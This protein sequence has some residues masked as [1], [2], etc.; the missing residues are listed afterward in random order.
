MMP[1][2]SHTFG[3]Q[4]VAQDERQRRIRRVFASVA[5]RYDLMNDAMS[6]GI[7]RLWKRSLARAAHPLPGQVI[8]DL[9]GGTGDVAKLMADGNRQVMVCDPS[10]E[11]MG[12]GR[13]RGRSHVSWLAG[14]GEGIPLASSSVDTLTI[15]FG[16]RNVT[17]L[18]RAL[19]EA[20]RVLKPGGRFLC[21]EFSRP[22]APIRPFYDLFSFT[23][24]PRLGAWIAREPEAYT[25]LVESIRRFPDQEAFKLTLEQ[26]GFAD[27]R[28]RNL[29]FGI[30]C[31]HRATKDE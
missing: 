14:S 26:A 18:E 30:A 16:I 19:G 11:M 29:S 5:R 2:L 22:W 10:L 17:S 6:F 4:D 9:A 24:I 15:A 12:V 27:V 25:Y 7:H 3:Y 31:L 21:L 8:V 23:V 28:Y 20:L 13:E 1:D